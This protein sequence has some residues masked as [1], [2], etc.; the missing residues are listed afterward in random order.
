MDL[1]EK[2]KTW[3]QKI[4]DYEGEIST[5]KILLK[6]AKQAEKQYLKLIEKAKALEK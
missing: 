5:I 2:L 3:Q 6:A 1:Q 4:A